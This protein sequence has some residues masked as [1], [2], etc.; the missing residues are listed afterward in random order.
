MAITVGNTSSI[1]IALRSGSVG[2]SHDNNGDFVVVMVCSGFGPPTTMTYDGVAMTLAVS[3]DTG[4]QSSFVYYA[5]ASA[6]GVKNISYFR[7]GG[8]E[9]VSII[10]MS[11]SGVAK[12]SPVDATGTDLTGPLASTTISGLSDGSIAVDALRASNT[13]GGVGFTQDAAQTKIYSSASGTNGFAASYK[14]PGSSS[15]TMSWIS[16]YSGAVRQAVAAFKAEPP[17]DTINKIFSF[18]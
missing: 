16:S 7:S 5:Y 15:T 4:G 3:A 17:R 13:S 2:L 14:F 8:A 12:S 1:A 18:S 9:Y 10:A 11:L 6:Q